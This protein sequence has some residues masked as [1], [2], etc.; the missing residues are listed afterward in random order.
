M[1]AQIH[2]HVHAHMQVNICERSVQAPEFNI[3]LYMCMHD[4]RRA[5]IRVSKKIFGYLVA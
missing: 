1:Y 3:S 5:R 4:E 2:V